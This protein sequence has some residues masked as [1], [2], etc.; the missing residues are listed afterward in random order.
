MENIETLEI[1]LRH[2]K[3]EN[4]VI[5]EQF[6]KTTTE[7]LQVLDELKKNRGHL[8]ESVKQ[9]VKELNGLYSLGKLTGKVENLEEL[10]C[11]FIK[12][13]VPESM[14]FPDKV[15]TK[16]EIDREEYHYPEE[17]CEHYLFAPIII[18]NKKRGNLIVG[19]TENLPF[20][21]KFEQQLIDGYAERLGKIIESMEAEDELVQM[22]DFAEHNPYPVLRLNQDG[23]ISLV[24]QATRDLFKDDN[25]IGKSWFSIYPEMGIDSFKGFFDKTN[26]K[27]L[28]VQI[29]KKKFLCTF[30]NLPE[31]NTI[32]FYGTDITELKQSEE[33]IRKLSIAVEQSPSS[34]V[35]TNIKGDI[36]YVNTKFTDV[37]GYTFKEAIGKN[38]RVVKSGKQ[39]PEIYK[40][41]WET[42]ASGNEWR[43]ELQN[44]KKNGEL[45][46]EFASISPIKNNNGEIT[47]F[48]AIKEDITKRKQIEE[49]LKLNDE[50]LTALLNLAQ[51]KFD[52]EKELSDYA[53]EKAVSLTNSEVG[54]LHHYNEEQ[55]SIQLTYWSKDVLKEC[56][57]G[58]LPH[59]ELKKAG[60]WA[61]SIR[62][63]K[64][65][66]H[67][68]Y[69]SLPDKKGCPEGHFP[70]IRHISVPIF[71][72]GNIVAVAGVGNKEEPYDE[73]DVR[74]LTLYM[75]SMWRVL[76]ER[77]ADKA[78]MENKDR[79]DRILKTSNEGFW[80]IDNELVTLD[81]NSAMCQ[82]LARQREDII[83]KKIYDFVDN[84]NKKIFQKQLQLREKDMENTYEIG[85]SRPD[86]TNITCLFNAT[87]FN[88]KVGEKIGSFAMVTDI[89]ERK[90]MEDELIIAKE[91]AETANRAKSDFL[92][93]MSHEL[94]TPLTA[95]IGFSQ[96][97]EMKHFGKLTEK[98]SEYVNNIHK[99]GKHLLSLINDILDLSKVEAGKMELELS[100]VKVKELLDGSLVMIKE[101]CH[102]HNISLDLKV[103]KE[104]DDLEITGDERKLKQVMY[105]L[106][107]NAAK[108]TP[109]NGAITVEAEKKQEGVFISVIDTGTG[110]SMKDQKKIFDEFYQVKGGITDKTPGTGLGLALVKQLVEMHGGRVSL[111]S[112]GIGKGSRFSFM[113]PINAKN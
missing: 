56:T 63:R 31:F 25:L 36:E 33:K 67:N 27:Q 21:E 41:L 51:R 102:N 16:V 23:T 103:S 18:N 64:P 19:Y 108:F 39:P 37:T 9:T 46:W 24:N 53:L 95:I 88:N 68:D 91:D 96:V 85:L 54:Y 29:G 80:F 81:V 55:Q 42:I 6:E 15:Y 75:S 89:A 28:E 52:S 32:N 45:Y 82:I 7:Y 17:K 47:H 60:I 48:I 3:N 20:I 111:E 78:L 106:L 11:N 50:R 30:K 35:I 62:L 73:S 58:K 87:P 22:A 61:D 70:V 99:S 76:K 38:P 84:E 79:L 10:I 69:Q 110:I 4:K 109:D 112:E 97:L 66:I 2:L 71:D 14:Q 43:G 107:S 12:N 98:Q 57:T 65:V 101:K 13:I 86:G 104:V 77:R 72:Y 26:I 40:Q 90:L 83:G 113:I 1:K 44:K 93:S 105:N 8:E 92:A 74:Q 100:E 34:I 94:R 5:K 49:V 59:S